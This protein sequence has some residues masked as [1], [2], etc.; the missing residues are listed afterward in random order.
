MTVYSSNNYRVGD[1]AD[2]E[3]PAAPRYQSGYN[4]GNQNREPFGS[5]YQQHS[6][7]GQHQQPSVG[8][9]HQQPSSGGYQR[10]NSASFGG[11]YRGNNNYQGTDFPSQAPPRGGGDFGRKM[12]QF[13]QETMKFRKTTRD[14]DF[15][16]MTQAQNIEQ[17]K[18]RGGV[19][20][21]KPLRR[22]EE[23]EL[24]IF[25][26]H[27]GV[28]GINFD[29]YDDIPVERTGEEISDPGDELA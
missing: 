15:F 26:D 24:E 8:G 2:Y 1:R 5:Q 11:N 4:G 17:D 6:Y 3:K 27:T 7:G 9:H 29:K 19:P 12:R 14:T 20:P 13:T 22:I 21:R 23:E 28:V 18:Q 10:D 25:R 16:W